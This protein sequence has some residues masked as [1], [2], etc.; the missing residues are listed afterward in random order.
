MLRKEHLNDILASL[1]EF[2]HNFDSLI[3][4]YKDVC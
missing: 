2:I 4:L 3:R 1:F